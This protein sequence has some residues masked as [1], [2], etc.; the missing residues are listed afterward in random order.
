[1][2]I[3]LSNVNNVHQRPCI[4]E[5]ALNWV[6]KMMH[7]LVVSKPLPLATPVTVQ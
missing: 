3:F 6:D 7:P 1:M 5:A 2:V 4:A